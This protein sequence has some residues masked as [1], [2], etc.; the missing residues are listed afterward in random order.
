MEN[1]NQAEPAYTSFIPQQTPQEKSSPLLVVLVVFVLILFVITGYLFWQ[2]QQLMVKLNQTQLSQQTQQIQV[3][4]TTIPAVAIAPTLQTA[5]AD[6]K[7]YSDSA[8]QFTLKYPAGITVDTQPNGPSSMIRFTQIGPTQ[9]AS[10]RTQ[11]SLT[12]GY[13]ITVLVSPMTQAV[14]L[15]LAADKERQRILSSPNSETCNVMNPKSGSLAGVPT[16]ELSATNCNG[17]FKTIFMTNNSHQ[18]QITGLIEGVGY[19][20]TVDQILSTFKFMENSQTN[21]PDQTAIRNLVT[22]FYRALT[23][24]DGKLLFSY[25]TPPTSSDEKGNYDW[26]TASDQGNQFYR[27]FLRSK[28]SDPQINTIQKVNNTTYNVMISDQ[29]P[30]FSNAGSTTG[31]WTPRTR[32]TIVIVA[33]NQSGNWFVDKF[34]DQSNTSNSGNAGTS[35]YNGFGQ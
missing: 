6:W 16:V 8:S 29:D 2:N 17:D 27:V 9:K 11:A 26:L 34:T 12:D 28:I 35:K 13:Q 30:N 31:A 20:N 4:P 7:T 22:N 24:H 23:N 14:D 3:V 15:N 18:Y 5:P 32:N 25:M 1:V 10:G 21:T 33:V 19:T